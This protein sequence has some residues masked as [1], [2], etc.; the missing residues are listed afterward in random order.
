M[1]RP[2]RTRTPIE[3]D[4]VARTVD[5][6]VITGAVK[7][8]TRPVSSALHTRHVEGPTSRRVKVPVGA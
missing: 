2:D 8:N 6:R 5:G 1:G 7:W 4:I 3:I